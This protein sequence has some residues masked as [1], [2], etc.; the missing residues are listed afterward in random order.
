ME[1]NKNDLIKM[2]KLHCQ[3]NWLTDNQISYYEILLDSIIGGIGDNENK[4]YKGQENDIELIL[5]E[6]K[7]YSDFKIDNVYEIIQ[8]DLQ[9]NFKQTKLY[10]RLFLGEEDET[11]NQLTNMKFADLKIFLE[12]NKLPNSIKLFVAYRES[13]LSNIEHLQLAISSGSLVFTREIDN[14]ET[15]NIVSNLDNLYNL[16]W[17]RLKNNCEIHLIFKHGNSFKTGYY[18]K[19]FVMKDNK[20]IFDMFL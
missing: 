18:V 2:I 9:W 13:S 16:Y 20:L 1:I 12:K 3:N 5:N 15:K 7:Q 14:G 4:Y 6:L 8:K 11:C 10:K 17:D 19:Q